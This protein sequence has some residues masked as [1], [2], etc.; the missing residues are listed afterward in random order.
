MR[1]EIDSDHV[2]KALAKA[3]VD[4]DGNKD[5]LKT[6]EDVEQRMRGLKRKLELLKEEQK[7]NIDAIHARVD[8]MRTL[9][10]IK[11]VEG[12]EYLAYTQKKLD[13]LIADYF[14]KTGSVKTVETF[15]KNRGVEKLVNTQ[16]LM[17]CARIVHSLENQETVECVNWCNE[18]KNSLKPVNNG[19]VFEIKLQCY[20]ELARKGDYKNAIVYFQKQLAKFSAV[21]LPEIKKASALLVYASNSDSD[22]PYQNLFSLDRWKLLSQLFI[23]AYHKVHQ[24]PM[25]SQLDELLAT[26]ISALNT[27]SCRHTKSAPIPQDLSR[28]Y[29]CPVCSDELCELGGQLPYAHHVK[30]HLPPDAVVL[31]NDRIYGRKQLEEFSRKSGKP[32]GVVLD[33]VTREIYNASSL[34][35][36][37]PS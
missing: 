1:I 17:E 8:Y 22:N 28:A 14:L 19:L 2:N 5:P 27:H 13:I 6:I 18:N 3:A 35:V 7:T 36:V 30:S 11:D 20:I 9:Y 12:P 37:Y 23:E 34:K 32:E 15:K 4:S 31:P 25:H 26:G 29:M 21:R 16:A 33:P 24:L 10:E